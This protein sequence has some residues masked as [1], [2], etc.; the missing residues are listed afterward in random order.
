MMD[1]VG[2]SENTEEDVDTG[3]VN[4]ELLSDAE[5]HLDSGFLIEIGGKTGLLAALLTTLFFS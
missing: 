3:K 4:P 5:F 2:G 1:G